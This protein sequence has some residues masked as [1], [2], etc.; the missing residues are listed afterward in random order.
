M[1]NR[2]IK[3]RK[4]LATFF[5]AGAI[6]ATLVFVGWWIVRWRVWEEEMNALRAM[7]YPGSFKEYKALWSLPPGTPNAADDYL[8]AFEEYTLEGANLSWLP[9]EGELEIPA[10]RVPFNEVSIREMGKFVASN[11]ATL[12]Y[13]HAGA[14]K[15]ICRIPRDL[16]TPDGLMGLDFGMEARSA[17]RLLYVASLY[18]AEKGDL[19]EALRDAATMSALGLHFTQQPDVISWLI[20]AAILDTAMGNLTDLFSRY[21]F[22][23][24]L[25]EIAAQP[26][27]SI[28]YKFSIADNMAGDFWITF[29]SYR[30]SPLAFFEYPGTGQRER[31]LFEA[32]AESL[33]YGAERLFGP[34]QEDWIDLSKQTRAYVA[35]SKQLDRKPF[36]DLVFPDDPFAQ[37]P[38]ANQPVGSGFSVL[39]PSYL[40]GNLLNSQSRFRAS[41]RSVRLVAAI[42]KYRLRFGQIP[43][44][45][46]ELVPGFIDTLPTDPF[47]GKSLRYLTEGE[48]Y[49]VY[50]A[51]NEFYDNRI[52]ASLNRDIDPSESG[53]SVDHDAPSTASE[54]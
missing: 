15:D 39:Q 52:L 18:H 11:E 25:L 24:E 5:V 37:G 17:A 29:A 34:N 44:D 40:L 28:E 43:Q 9:I 49:S 31:S 50:S 32:I 13:L 27:D 19:E 51:W 7:G 3:R 46:E 36:S 20:G 45:L 6:V 35:L 8:N 2:A 30:L 47:N 41:F 21:E 1:T 53:L 16:E 26:Y 4:P 38:Q 48:K 22:T 14:M 42:E 23:D 10:A 12:N 33:S 54:L